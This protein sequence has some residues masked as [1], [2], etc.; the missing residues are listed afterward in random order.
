MGAGASRPLWVPSRY[1]RGSP[2]P[3]DTY[4]LPFL[5]R[6]GRTKLGIMA[7]VVTFRRGVRSVYH[8]AN[9][10]DIG[11]E[12]TFPGT[13]EPRF[14]G[15]HRDRASFSGGPTRELFEIA[16]DDRLAKDL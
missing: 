6:I 1:A 10:R 3:E 8:L 9:P 13:V 14:E 15:T 11:G 16:Q 5:L 2:Q 4:I 7:K 12:D